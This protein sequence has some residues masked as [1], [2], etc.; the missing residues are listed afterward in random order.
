MVPEIDRR[1]EALFRVAGL[2]LPQI[3]VTDE[4]LAGAAAILVAGRPA[5]GYVQIDEVDGAAHVEELA[6]LPN[7]MRSGIGTAL[8]TA[9]CDWAAAE[10]YRA[11]T[12][13]TFADVAWNAP[14]YAARGFTVIDD[15]T[16][17]LAARRE[18]ERDLGLDAVGR[19]V[20]MRRALTS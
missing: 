11:I 8:L 20:V 3:I 2:D 17:G 12:L 4:E 15:L 10:G 19:R 13:T 18:R 14:F 1:A 9:A 7:R 16:P 5:V 6:V